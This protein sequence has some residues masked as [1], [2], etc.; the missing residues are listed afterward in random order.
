MVS[1]H[2]LFVSPHI[3]D[4]FLSLG[5][6]L[7][8]NSSKR[9]KVVNVF[10]VTDFAPRGGCPKGDSDCVSRLRKR[11]ELANCNLI[12]ADVDFLP[13]PD[14]P[15]RGYKRVV[16]ESP[17]L[18]LERDLIRQIKEEIRN[19]LLDSEQVFLPLAI[20][21]H[22]DHVLTCRIGLEI[23]I[24][25]QCLHKTY[26]YEDQPYSTT[27]PRLYSLIDL[28]KGGARLEPS[29]ISFPWRKKW[30]LCVT[31]QSQ[32]SNKVYRKILRY[33]KGIKVLGAFYER[34]WQVKSEEY[35]RRLLQNQDSPGASID[36]RYQA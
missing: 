27:K 31:Y 24:E 13:F 1:Y 15:M 18:D 3:D 34:I 20:G 9:Q 14:A 25:E 26:F 7:A 17:R 36:F 10:A 32:F 4:A 28:S 35:V 5:G 33:S 21:R 23:G 6:T 2:N 30:N 12:G 16:D 11:E 29:L 8:K 22:V 19:R